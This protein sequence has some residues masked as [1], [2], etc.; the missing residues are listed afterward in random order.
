LAR[1]SPFEKSSSKSK[2]LHDNQLFLLPSSI[3]IWKRRGLFIVSVK[4]MPGIASGSALKSVSYSL[5]F[6]AVMLFRLSPV[7]GKAE[8]RIGSFPR[9]GVP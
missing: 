1:D 3:I 9:D 4:T 7:S 5:P 2:E 6:S 8:E